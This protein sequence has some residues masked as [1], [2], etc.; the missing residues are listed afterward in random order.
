ME[1]RTLRDLIALNAQDPER[2]LRHGQTVLVDAEA[3]SGSLREPEYITARLRDLR[4]SRAEGI[5]RAMAVHHLDALLFAGA[6]GSAIAACGG[7]PSV[8]V[9]AGYTR[10]GQPVGA[11]FTAGAFAEPT[12]IALTYAYEQATHHRH[13]P[14]L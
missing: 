4:L 14:L 12:L 11:T 10:E 13:S 6:R 2:M 5:D 7:Y 3:K 1:V 8:S 9:P